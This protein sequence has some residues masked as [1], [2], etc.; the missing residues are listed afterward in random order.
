MTVGSI[1]HAVRELLN[2][3]EPNAYRW[4]PPEVLRS[5]FDAIQ[6]LASVRPDSRYVGLRL[7]TIERPDISDDADN[8]TIEAVRN[9]ELPIDPRWRLALVHFC[10]HR[11]YEMDDTDT[12]NAALSV[13]HLETFRMWSQL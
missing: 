10:A 3:K 1:E 7:Q 12:V 11:C 6:S 8:M 13:K 5:V 9:T 2:D 4:K